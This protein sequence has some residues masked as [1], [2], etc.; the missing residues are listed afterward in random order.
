VEFIALLAAY[1]YWIVLAV[2]FVDQFGTPIPSIAIL[3]A[4]GAVAGQGSLSLAGV[5]AAAWLGTVL[6]DVVLYQDGRW[7]GRVV[8]RHLCSL[9]LAPDTCVR[10][11]EVSFERLGWTALVIAKFVPGL[12]LFAAPVAG[13]LQMPAASFLF[14]DAIGS[15]LYNVVVIGLGYVF[16]DQLDRVVGW[17]RAAGSAAVPI[18]VGSIVAYCAWRIVQKR[19]VIHELRTRRLTPAEVRA[20]LA[21]GTP[22]SIVDLRSA[23]DFERTRQV[24]PGAIRMDPEELDARHAEIPRNCDIVLYCTCPNEAT[25]ARAALA[26]KKRGV[27]RV[28]PLDG[29]LEAW[30][31]CGYPVDVAPSRV[32]LTTGQAIGL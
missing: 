9:S 12:A 5:L 19:R 8:M 16:H 17:F 27:E 10:K 18:V 25:S 29:G 11:T 21:S 20:R 24:M 22:V 3:L 23:L 4:A 2:A 26:L 6:G 28:Y 32:G 1:G 13:T 14:F 30:M 31:Q 7:R 15:V